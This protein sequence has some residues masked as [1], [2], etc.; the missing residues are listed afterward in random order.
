[1]NGDG[2][3]DLIVGAPAAGPNGQYSGASYVVFGKASGFAANIDLSTLNGSNGFKLSGAAMWNWSGSAVASAGDFNGDG[4]A[5]LIV[6]ASGTYSTGVDSGTSYVVFGKASGFAADIDLSMLDGSTGFAL[7][8]EAANDKSGGSVASAGDVNGDGYDDLIIGASRADPNGANTGASYVVF[9]GAFGG[10]ATPVTTTGTVTAEILIGRRG[11]DVLNGGGGGDVFHAGAGDDRLTAK[12]LAFRLA[13]GGGG[14]DT[15]AL[16]GSGLSLDLSSLLV[17]AKLEGIERI[18]LGGTGNTLIVNQL[19]ILGGVGAVE[20]GRHILVVERN[21]GDTVQFVEPGWAK[22]GSFTNADGT[23]DRWVL[24]N[25]EVHVA[26]DSGVTII[27]TAG[28]DIIST[29]V[30]VPGQPFA[31]ELGDFID[32]AGGADRMAGGPGD[33]TYVVDNAGDVVTEVAGEGADTVNASV[34]WT[35]GANVENLIQTGS[36]SINGFGN[37]LA[38]VIEGNSGSNVLLGGDGA[39]ALSGGDSA[40]YLLIDGADAAIDGGAGFDSAFVQTATPV[41]L[42]MGA[43][44]IEWV[45]G[46]AGNDVFDAASQS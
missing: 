42:D 14:T 44:S 17:T 46:N 23:F 25:A 43:S 6:G 29:T 33:D 21:L 9:G 35:L 24:G 45:Q 30:S 41:T 12:D 27:G 32:G 40:D 34:S 38:N 15:L 8:G 4:F 31:T 3:A 26:Q 5:D 7:W 18:D 11:D 10:S 19:S 37:D 16:G 2:Y 28:N 20:N 36:A 22:T 39:D 1:V 13:D